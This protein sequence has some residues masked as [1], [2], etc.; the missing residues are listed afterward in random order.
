METRVLLVVSTDDVNATSTSGPRKDYNALA[1]VLGA[2]TIDRS[3]VRRSWLSR[4]LARFVGIAPMQA[5]H[6]FSARADFDV[7]L[8]DGEHVGIPLALLLK[9]SRAR[10]RHVTIG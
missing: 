2:T 6:A 5:W 10:V 9:L 7:I 8:T 1:E 3:H 4:T